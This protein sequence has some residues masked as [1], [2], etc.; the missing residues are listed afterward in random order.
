M[1]T[2]KQRRPGPDRRETSLARGWWV[3]CPRCGRDR[4][5]TADDLMRSGDW[6][7]CPHCAGGD[8]KEAA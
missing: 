6:T 2:T 7:R 8:G 4:L 1:N 5:V 3:S